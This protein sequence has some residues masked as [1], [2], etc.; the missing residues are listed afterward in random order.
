MENKAKFI[1]R[2]DKITVFLTGAY[3]FILPLAVTTLSTDALTIPKQALLAA[4]VFVGLILLGIKAVLNEGVRLRRTPFDLPL[5]L[6]TIA[7]LISAIL[8]VNRFDSFITFVPFLFAIL[9]YFVITNSV[10]KSQDF[11]FLSGSLIV[12]AIVVSAITLLSYLKIYIIPFEFAKFQTFTPFGSL[13]DQLVYLVLIL[14]FCLYMAWPALKRRSMDKSRLIYVIGA[15][16]LVIGVA[17][18]AIATFTLQKPTILPP[19]T[20]F[21]TALAAIS[22]DNARVVQG[23]LSGSGIGTF[24]VDFSK[25][26]PASFNSANDIWGN[27]LWTVSFFRSSSYFLELIA[28]T[29][30]L[31]V[32]TF[33]FLVW[34][35]IR[36]KPLFPPL[37]LAIILA[38]FIPFSYTIIL[39]FFI[40]L[41]IY[42]AQ[43]GLVERQRT[44]FFDVELKLL[45]LKQG[46]FAL[47]DP[48]SRRESSYGNFLPI[49]FLVITI[50]FA[51][52]VGFPTAKFIYS[53]YLFQKSIVTAN[54]G[55]IQLTF[56]LQGKAINTF[57]Q[58]D[59]YSRIF[60]QLNLSLAN[61]V[62]SSIPQGA[63]PS[64]EQAN[65]IYQL[66]QNS[67]NYG[68]QA[69]TISPQNTANWQNLASIYR[70][71]IGFGQN[72]DSFAVV[73]TQQSV[74]L[75]P[76]NP[77]QY[78]NYGGIFYQLGRWDDAIRQ[79]QIAATLKPDY[80]NAYYNL[81]HAYEQKGD[82]QT[83]LEQYQKVKILVVSDKE[84]TKA[85]DAEIKAL[86]GKIGN[87]QQAA[88]P[89]VPT[90]SDEQ[91]AP[92]GVNQPNTQLPEQKNQVKIPGPSETPAKSPTP[93]KNPNQ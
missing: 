21:Q 64:A 39:L 31:G 18:T 47:D 67:I 38:F 58:R 88:N 22:Q 1:S 32:I 51:L 90:D 8:A 3:L 62:A 13:F 76:N 41:A 4:L 53:D 70:S 78:I 33:L 80:A 60:S 28:T 65:T 52:L 35:I 40:L 75:D 66:I 89:E 55:D 17:I 36:T 6:F 11:L 34:R 84:T 86:Q 14:V 63:S 85:I 79:F 82:L 29:G 27:P 24:L 12:G 20:G 71:L 73:A 50:L 59:S 92:I 83:A 19:I 16:V 44:K 46:I 45:S 68:R 87:N 48:K 72:A 49:A 61:N 7:T 23:F 26:K 5:I 81:G 57:P 93:T 74:L 69:T 56:D 15:F 25:F 43:Q 10:K 2:I 9:L 54:K 91:Q 37:I 42:S 77:Q 30:L